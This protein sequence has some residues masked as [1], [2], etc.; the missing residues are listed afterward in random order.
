MRAAMLFAHAA[1]SPPSAALVARCAESSL[2]PPIDAARVMN[3]ISY[4][5]VAPKRTRALC[6]R[7]R[8]PLRTALCILIH[9]FEWA[10]GPDDRRFLA[11]CKLALAIRDYMMRQHETVSTV[12]HF[13]ASVAELA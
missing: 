9:T 10:C 3:A 8:L 7:P 13:K 4:H 12:G 6:S 1:Q 2:P 5:K 11:Y